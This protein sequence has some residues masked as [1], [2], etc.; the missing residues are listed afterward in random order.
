MHSLSIN[1]LLRM[2]FESVYEDKLRKLVY[3]SEVDSKMKNSL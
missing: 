3:L 1:F 2:I